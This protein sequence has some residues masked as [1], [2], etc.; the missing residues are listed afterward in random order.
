LR[1]AGK[2]AVYDPRAEIVHDARRASRRQP[3]LALQHLK[4][5]LR[6]LSRG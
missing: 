2:S 5:A 4:S 3:A 1:K 6:F